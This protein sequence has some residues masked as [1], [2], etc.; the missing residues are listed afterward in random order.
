MFHEICELGSAIYLFNR[1]I[2]IPFDFFQLLAF[3]SVPS[4]AAR[5]LRE[6]LHL[7]SADAD[8]RQAYL[9]ATEAR[10]D[11]LAA[12]ALALKNPSSPS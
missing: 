1:P 10:C 8:G 12:L 2:L 11:V 6:M 5:A 3:A 9:K 4:S 7:L